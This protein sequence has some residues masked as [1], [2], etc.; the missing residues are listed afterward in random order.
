MSVY[1]VGVADRGMDSVLLGVLGQK[2][3]N[4]HL[5]LTLDE[6]VGVWFLDFV[7]AYRMFHPVT[8]F[9]AVIVITR[10]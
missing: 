7:D 3:V 2:R 8:F 1:S 10:W 9:R 5:W 6:P 4:I